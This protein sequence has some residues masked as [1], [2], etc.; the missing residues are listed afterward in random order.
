MNYNQFASCNHISLP[1]NSRA[2]LDTGTQCNYKCGFCYYIN[3]LD[4]A[5]SFEVIKERIDNLYLNNPDIDEIDLSG[6]ESTIH[7]DWFKIL[8]Y[9]NDKFLSIS[10]LSNGSKLKDFEFA[11][12]S[13]SHGLREVLF[14]LHGYDEQSHD[15]IVGHKRA[16]KHIIQAIQNCK[17]LGI[18]VRLNCTVTSD[19][20]SGLEM[21]AM[22]VKNLEVEQI[23]FL[24]LNYWSDAKD[25]N[26]ESYEIL[27]DGIKSAINILCETN[28]QINVRYIPHCFMVGY[29]KYVVGI[30]QHIFDLNDWNIISYDN[31]SHVDLHIEDY[32]WT[33]TQKRLQSYNKDKECFSCKYF[34]IC[35][36][37]EHKLVGL[38][39]VYPIEGKKITDPMYYRD[40]ERI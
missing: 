24:P 38:Q 29:E 18:K 35:D 36:G 7:K 13:Q 32:Y 31:K 17:I 4:K 2:K 14:S 1:R 22:L 10:C 5:T 21:Y 33:A 34:N 23:N 11:Y 9:C 27:S 16:F 28:I 20:V 40:G 19:N 25:A 26:P 30:Y 37:I 39:N 8:D 12:E 6:G 15:E 3:D